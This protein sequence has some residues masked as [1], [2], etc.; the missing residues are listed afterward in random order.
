MAPSCLRTKTACVLPCVYLSSLFSYFAHS[1][2]FRHMNSDASCLLLT[3][4]F[5]P[6]SPSHTLSP[7]IVLQS[8]S[9]SLKLLYEAFPDPPAGSCPLPL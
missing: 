2:S 8:P 1:Y 3:L 5:P 6:G 9:P 7:H 4:C